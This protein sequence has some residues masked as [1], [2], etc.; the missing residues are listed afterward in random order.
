LGLFLRLL[1]PVI[2]YAHARS[3]SIFLDP[4]TDTYIL[5]ARSLI[6]AHRFYTGGTPEIIRT[7]GYPILLTLGLFDHHLIRTTVLV[8]IML[9]CA[10][11]YLVYRSTKLIFANEASG[12]IAATLYAVEPLSIL[13]C[14]QLLTET[15]FTFL[16]TLWLYSLLK[17]LRFHHLSLLLFSAVVLAASIYVRP[18]GYFLPIY[19]GAVL[20]GFAIFAPRRHAIRVVHAVLFALVAVG[21]LLP[22]QIRNAKEARYPGFAGISAVNMYFYLAASVLAVQHHSAFFTE[23]H[24]LG[25]LN[26]RIYFAR[27]P[28]QASWPQGAR[29][30]F[31]ETEAHRILMQNKGL[32]F[33]IHLSGIARALLD[34]GATSW[35][36]FFEL[37]KRGGGILGSL[38]DHSLT[39]N[40]YMLL[41]LKP[42]VFWTNALLFPFELIYLL[43]AFVTVCSKRLLV[44]RIAVP[45]LI[46]IYYL[47]IA[48]GPA[49][50][51]RFKHPAM[52]IISIL[53]GFGIL[54]VWSWFD[55]QSQPSVASYKPIAVN[56]RSPNALL[57]IAESP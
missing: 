24:E 27:H 53:A 44:P 38:D 14:S 36:I 19:V 49:A 54:T 7:P 33:K 11:I 57:T 34:S 21:L 13:Y 52:P 23:Q 17:Y 25:Y 2:G 6:V 42:L 41:R 8:Q 39:K 20:I 40:V 32:Y 51:G 48:G 50:L 31:I 43:G 35:L 15:L 12:L 9:S 16:S 28:E 22:W 47:V 26:D 4:D 46:V 3:T 10:T 29:L 37:Y 45:F 18:I 5:P 56:Y 55:A 1:F 30:N